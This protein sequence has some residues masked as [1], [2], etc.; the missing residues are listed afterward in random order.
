MSFNFIGKTIMN[1]KKYNTLL[2]SI[3]ITSVTCHG[4]NEDGKTTSCS[5]PID[6]QP[7][8]KDCLTVPHSNQ[9]PYL[10]GGSPVEGRGLLETYTIITNLGEP[11]ASTSTSKR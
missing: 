11:K 8:Q 3:V 4:M 6:I 5:T 2:L 1:Y 7:P 9:T 10:F